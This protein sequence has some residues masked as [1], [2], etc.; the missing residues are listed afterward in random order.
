[1]NT[2]AGER[3]G[4]TLIELMIV[5]AIVAILAAVAYP[6]YIGYITKTRRG[7]AEACLS[8]YANY[9]ERYYTTNL[10]YETPASG[11]SSGSPIT[12]P[13][14]D[15]AGTTQTGPYYTY[16]FPAGGA[17]VSASTYEIDAVPGGVQAQRDTGCGTLSITQAGTRSETGSSGAACWG[18]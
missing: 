11:G 17:G 2:H 13:A 9:M 16:Q 12:L 10:T 6:T 18:H 4:F 14:L 3:R 15:C 7:A 8:E 5:V 1:M